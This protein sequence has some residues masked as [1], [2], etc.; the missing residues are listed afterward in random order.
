MK[1]TLLSIGLFCLSFA[2]NAQ[3]SAVATLNEN[4]ENF[5]EGAF[6]QNCWTSNDIFPRLSIATVGGSKV[7]QTYTSSSPTTPIY[8]VSPEL[9]TI[10]GNHKL[11]FNIGAPSAPG[12]L[13]L[14]VG[15]MSSPTAYTS[16]VA[17]GS[18]IT[19]TAASA[20]SN[21]IIPASTT[22]KH[23]VFRVTST[24]P[25]S[26]SSIDN[27]VYEANLS[28]AESNLTTF[29]VYPNPSVNKIVTIS[30]DN[31]FSSDK[32][33]VAIYSLTGAKV[34]ETEFSESTNTLNLS[35]LASGV[36]VLKI[37]SGDAVTTKKLVLK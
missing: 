11:S 4:F 22:Q 24:A 35:E 16:F 37:N 27:V 3:C 19:V 33:A 21:I 12:T 13:K 8:V 28:V 2:S 34:F 6:P 26:V 1:K 29:K 5:V 23:I 31:T 25:H 20:Q 36:Y 9:S 10:D 30:Q 32:N 18:E 14:Q 15:T 7:V 17:V